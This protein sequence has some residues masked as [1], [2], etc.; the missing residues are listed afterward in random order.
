MKPTLR[1]HSFDHWRRWSLIAP[2]PLKILIHLQIIIWFPIKFNGSLR[3]KV[4]CKGDSEESIFYNTRNPNT[5]ASFTFSWYITW[6]LKCNFLKDMMR[7]T[8][9]TQAVNEEGVESWSLPA[10]TFSKLSLLSLILK[11]GYE[12]HT[13]VST[14]A[15]YVAVYKD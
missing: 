8:S 13:T 7:Q 2:G 10:T 9:G 5:Q 14:I 4:D 6:S 3:T 15:N 1:P 12:W 11:G